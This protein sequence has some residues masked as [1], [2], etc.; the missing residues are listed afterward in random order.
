MMKTPFKPTIHNPHK[1]LKQEEHCDLTLPLSPFIFRLASFLSLSHSLSLSFSHSL[2]LSFSHSLSLFLTLFFKGELCVSD[3]ARFP[4]FLSFSL[5][6][7]STLLL[8][9]FFWSRASWKK[10]RF[11]F[12]SRPLPILSLLSRRYSKRI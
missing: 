10:E 4:S 2:S 9:V 12:G 5:V 3:C 8:L 11:T 7:F 6:T 1:V